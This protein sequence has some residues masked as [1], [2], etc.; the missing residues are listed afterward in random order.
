MSTLL[1]RKAGSHAC[2][3][4]PLL[5]PRRD[6]SRRGSQADAA[7]KIRDLG[8]R[9]TRRKHPS[10]D[11][12]QRP[13]CLH[14]SMESWNLCGKNPLRPSSPTIPPPL[15]CLPLHYG[16][17]SHVH[18]YPHH[19]T[20]SKPPGTPSTWPVQCPALSVLI[21]LSKCYFLC[22]RDMFFSA[23]HLSV[24]FSPQEKTLHHIQEAS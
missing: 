3:S 19:P 15:P 21:P 17:K 5:F 18:V 23:S 8:A 10:P 22:L 7:E 11:A 4:Q 24:L 13:S 20:C 12:R 1:P 2:L 6:L 16:P 9:T 14:I